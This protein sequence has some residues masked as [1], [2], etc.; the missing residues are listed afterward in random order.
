M[1]LPVATCPSAGQLMQT[2]GNLSS[3]ALT[4]AFHEEFLDEFRSLA[5]NATRDIAF[6]S[7]SGLIE[8]G[9]VGRQSDPHYCQPRTDLLFVVPGR[10]AIGNIEYSAS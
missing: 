10:R 7:S 2:S 1:W 6:C 5:R 8:P 4:P 3:Y 9:W